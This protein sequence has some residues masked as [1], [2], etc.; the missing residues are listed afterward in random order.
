M[1]DLSAMAFTRGFLDDFGDHT[2][3]RSGVYPSPSM[4]A[5]AH[6][7]LHLLVAGG[8]VPCSE[9][10]K[11]LVPPIGTSALFDQRSTK[12]HLC[13]LCRRFRNATESLERREFRKGRRGDLGFRDP[14]WTRGCSER[15][16]KSFVRG[17]NPQCPTKD[18]PVT[19]SRSPY[20]TAALPQAQ[21][22]SDLTQMSRTTCKLE[23]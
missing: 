22:P 8:E 19:P 13:A 1:C 17:P 15:F 4:A 5:T 11:I 9:H 12:A 10:G 3:S 18:A 23:V 20:S 21:P 16:G 7:Q 2:A 14:E 6:P